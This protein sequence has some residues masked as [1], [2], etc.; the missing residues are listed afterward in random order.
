MTAVVTAFNGTPSGGQPDDPA[1][2]PHNRQHHHGPDRDPAHVGPAVSF[3]KQLNVIVPILPLGFVITHFETTIPQLLTVKGKKAKKG[4]K[5]VP[6][7]YYVGAK[8]STKKWDFQGPLLLQQRCVDECRCLAGVQAEG[9]QE[10]EE[11]VLLHTDDP[12]GRPSGRPFHLHHRIRWA[13]T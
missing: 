11:V 5:A 1:A 9:V 13:R 12:K 3:G 6:A 8:C 7:K 2:Q 10:E 4:K